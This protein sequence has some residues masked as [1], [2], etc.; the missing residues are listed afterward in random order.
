MNKKIGMED[1]IQHYNNLS[2]QLLGEDFL[3]KHFPVYMEPEQISL[4]EN[5]L[6]NFIDKESRLPFFLEYGSGGSTFHFPK[7]CAGLISIEHDLK[8]YFIINYFL[9]KYSSLY[10]NT[11][12]LGSF[13]NV[14]YSPVLSKIRAEQYE[15]ASFFVNRQIKFNDDKLYNNFKKPETVKELSD[16]ST[17]RW[18]CFNEYIVS[19]MIGKEKFTN[20]TPFDFV[21]LDGRCRPEVCHFIYTNNVIHDNSIVFYDDYFNDGREDYSLCLGNYKIIDRVGRMAVVKPKKRNKNE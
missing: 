10:K 18:K 11:R 14:D 8:W 15:S 20:D 2:D 12:V 9:E 16:M 5:Y 7:F 19:S 17:E 3:K 13:P 21:L 4:I 1:Y 6:F